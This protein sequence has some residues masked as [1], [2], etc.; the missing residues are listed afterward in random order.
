MNMIECKA[1]EQLQVHAHLHVH[2]HEHEQNMKQEHVSMKL[3]KLFY[4]VHLQVH[5]WTWK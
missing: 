2:Q 4:Y 1:H 3:C 5:A